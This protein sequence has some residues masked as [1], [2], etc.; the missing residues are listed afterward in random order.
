MNYRSYAK[1]VKL[2]AGYDLVT[3]A[4]LALPPFVP[5]ILS[6]VET[7]DRGSGLSTTFT[8]R[9]TTTVFLINLAGCFA[10]FWAIVRLRDPSI[11]NGRLDGLLRLTIVVCQIWCVYLGASLL[12]LGLSVPLVLIAI[13]ELKPIDYP[14]VGSTLKKRERLN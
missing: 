3:T 8:G 10:L 7:L 2:V 12:L 5:L 1:L 6:F 14:E 9:D 4:P 13:F 11:A